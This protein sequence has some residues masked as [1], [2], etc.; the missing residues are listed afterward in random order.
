M[1]DLS[2]RTATIEKIFE[3]PIK[4]V[5]EAWTNPE[6]IVKWWAPGGMKITVVKHDFYVGGEWKY[7]MPM[8]DGK[9]FVSGGVYKE[10]V[11]PT[12]IITSAEFKPMT[13][14]V[15]LQALFEA[16]GDQTKFT[17]H[18][19]HP[20]PEYLKQQEEM[21]IYNGWGS[22]FERFGAMVIELR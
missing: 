12:R 20:T 21:G 1:N 4:T 10:I 17:F 15:E 2:N 8:P 16:V 14:G 6:H 19:I 3:A 9:E 5:W 22:V 11:E 13:E 18:I 7:T